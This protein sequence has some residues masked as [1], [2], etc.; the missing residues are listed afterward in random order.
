MTMTDPIAD[1]LTRIRNASRAGL[2]VVDIPC[3]KLKL[4]IARILK[5]QG[6]IINYDKV[7]D[8]KQGIIKIAL[9][10]S[11]NKEEIFTKLVRVSKPSLRVCLKAGDIAPVKSGAGIAIVSTSK[12]I[13]SDEEC[14]KEN[15]GGEVLCHIW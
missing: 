14:R 12:G 6:F 13:K 11:K 15:L 8:S 1:M 9:R 4:E 3:S 2:L 10:Y 7:D 5:E